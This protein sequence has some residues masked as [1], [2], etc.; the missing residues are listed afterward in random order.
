M[1]ISKIRAIDFHSHFNHGNPSD[2]KESAVY[3]CGLDAI[4]KMNEAANVAATVCSPFAAVLD[5]KTVIEENEYLYD[6]SQRI[7]QLFQWVVIDPRI[8]E[9]FSQAKRMLHTKKC[10]GIKLH[11]PLHGYST[12]EYGEKLFSFADD[13]NAVV[14]IHPEF[15]PFLYLKYT[16][17]YKNMIL[18]IAHMADN[19]FFRAAKESKVGNVYLD[20][21]GSASFQNF[22]I[23]EAVSQGLSERI[24]Y[25]SD[26][27]AVGAQRGRI[28][29]AQIPDKDKALILRDNAVRIFPEL[30]KT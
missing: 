3:K 1:D 21:S 25:G 14:Q 2:S 17:K 27:Y 9:T 6:L 7:P 8:E 16:D 22:V 29:Y 19:D 5:S 23:E 10:L 11:P 13:M 30:A 26:T 4:L 20:T 18:D 28:E 15:S 24:L 12:D